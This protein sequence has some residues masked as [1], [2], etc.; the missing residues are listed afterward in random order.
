MVSSFSFVIHS[1][2]SREIFFYK[3]KKTI[4][5]IFY[6]SIIKMICLVCVSDRRV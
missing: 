3:K 6:K 2:S 4:D 5:K 1:A